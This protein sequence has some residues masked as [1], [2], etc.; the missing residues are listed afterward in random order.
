MIIYSIIYLIL[1]LIGLGLAVVVHLNNVWTSDGVTIQSGSAASTAWLAI[2]GVSIAVRILTLVGAGI[3]NKW[4]VGIAALWEIIYVILLI[5]VGGTKPVAF[6]WSDGSS[7]TPVYTYNPAATIILTIILSG[8][9][10]YVSCY[11][12]FWV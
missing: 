10:F 12:I 7:F 4:M 11:I 1:D 8:L 9:I 6:A 5:V 3:Y 2:Y